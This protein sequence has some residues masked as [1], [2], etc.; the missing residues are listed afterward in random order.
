VAAGKGGEYLSYGRL[1][2]FGVYGDALRGVDAAEPHIEALVVELVG[3]PGE[4]LGD[5]PSRATWSWW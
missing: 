4:S 3:R 5:L 1:I 2:P